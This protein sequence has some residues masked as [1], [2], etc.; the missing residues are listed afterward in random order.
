MWCLSLCVDTDIV[1]RHP[2][3]QRTHKSVAPGIGSLPE[4]GLARLQPHSKPAYSSTW[5]VYCLVSEV[6]EVQSS[7][8]ILL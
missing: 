3:D 1:A 7:G 4:N 2:Q 8:A 6:P 5:V